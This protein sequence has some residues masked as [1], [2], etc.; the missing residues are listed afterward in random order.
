MFPCS[1]QPSTSG[2]PFLAAASWPLSTSSTAMALSPSSCRN[3]A[4]VATA[5]WSGPA[6]VWLRQSSSRCTT[7]SVS[8]SDPNRWPVWIRSARSSR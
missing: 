5:S 4:M 6:G 3:A 8:V 2:E 1:P 7:T